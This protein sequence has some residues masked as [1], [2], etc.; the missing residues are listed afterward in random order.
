MPQNIVK[1]LKIIRNDL[2]YIKKHMFDSDT[3]MTI[4]EEKRFK[5]S[6]KELNERKTTP[7]SNIKK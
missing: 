2:E 7:L 5:H 1:E 4:E 3:I 6:L